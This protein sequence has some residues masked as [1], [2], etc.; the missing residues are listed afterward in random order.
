[1]GPLS[2]EPFHIVSNVT[3]LYRSCSICDT[4]MMIIEEEERKKKLAGDR[5]QRERELE[6]KERKQPKE[7]ERTTKECNT[8]NRR[9]S[10]AEKVKEEARGRTKGNEDVQERGNKEKRSKRVGTRPRWRAVTVDETRGRGWELNGA[11][12]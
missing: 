2:Y 8:G 6:G 4:W 1:M 7:R 5:V 10:V 9:K 11:G 12:S 3:Q